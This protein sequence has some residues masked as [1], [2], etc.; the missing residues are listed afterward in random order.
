MCPDKKLKWF[1]ERGWTA[2]AIEE[3]RQLVLHRWEESYKP[4]ATAVITPAATL[5]VPAAVCFPF[6]IS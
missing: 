3:V 1:E 6:G 5:N 2:E 4:T